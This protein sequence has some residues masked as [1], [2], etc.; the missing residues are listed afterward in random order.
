MYRTAVALLML[1]A[2][3]TLAAEPARL[4]F[5]VDQS[6]TLSLPATVTSVKID[7]P[8][9]VEATQSGRKVTLHGLAKGHTYAVIQTADGE[10]RFR[11]YVAADRFALP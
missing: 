8:S 11:I 6:T 5:T 7:D 9:L 10:H 3:P 1:S 4:A 2:A